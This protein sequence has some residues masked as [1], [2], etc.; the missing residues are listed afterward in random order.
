MNFWQ[1]TMELWAY[2]PALSSHLDSCDSAW[3]WCF[4]LHNE[5]IQAA[6]DREQGF[7]MD[8]SRHSA[9]AFHFYDLLSSR[10]SRLKLHQYF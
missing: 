8:H 3:A 5:Q 1:I 7:C 6:S 10:Y 2:L 9:D 4:L